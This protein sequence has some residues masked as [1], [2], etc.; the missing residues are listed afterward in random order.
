ML[1]VSRIRRCGRQL[2]IQRHE[3]GHSLN[4]IQPRAD[5]AQAITSCRN[6]KIIASRSA[7]KNSNSDHILVNINSDYTVSYEPFETI[8]NITP[9]ISDYLCGIDIDVRVPDIVRYRY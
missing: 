5:Y 1:S 9:S 8:S 6:R 2:P 4:F 7:L 3:V